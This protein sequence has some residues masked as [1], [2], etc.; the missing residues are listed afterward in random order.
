MRVQPTRIPAP[1][2]RRCRS[3]TRRCYRL[4]G[5]EEG[6]FHGVLD[7]GRAVAAGDS[8]AGLFPVDRAG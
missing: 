8:L 7:R 1:R 3:R 5:W 6:R 4:C 2:W